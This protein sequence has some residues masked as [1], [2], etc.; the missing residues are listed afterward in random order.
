[1]K[2]KEK[3]IVLSTAD[4]HERLVKAMSETKSIYDSEKFK[5]AREYLERRKIKIKRLRHE[6]T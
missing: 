3:P 5:E 4:A 1:M 2:Q 6:R